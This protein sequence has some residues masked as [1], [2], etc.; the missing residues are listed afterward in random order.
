ME[1]E[2]IEKEKMYLAGLQH[3]GFM[4]DEGSVEEEIDELWNRFA[5]FCRSR[6]E[7]IEDRVIDP[8]VSY[9]I[10]IWNEEQLKEEG[11]LY[12]FVGV[13]MQDIE[14]LPLQLCGKVLP[15]SKYLA[16]R[17]EGEEIKTWEEDILQ[18]WFPRDD[19]WIRDYEG[20]I[21]HIQCFHEEKFKGV[22]DLENSE[23]KVLIPVHEVD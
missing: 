17:L 7:D 21:F 5:Q 8:Y 16:F 23:L 4:D 12:T 19:Y 2:L 13:E 6:W 18:D 10:Q 1:H 11:K 15:E 20:F 14:T 3:T 22:E 9:E